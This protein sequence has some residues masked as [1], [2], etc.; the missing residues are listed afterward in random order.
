[1]DGYGTE[2]NDVKNRLFILVSAGMILPAAFLFC[3]AAGLPHV[4]IIT[5]TGFIISFVVKKPIR[6]SDR[7]IIYSIVI[8]LVLVVLLNMVFPIRADRFFHIGRLLMSHISAPFMLYLAVFATFYESSSYT[9]GFN[10]A[11]ALITLMFG[12]DFRVAGY[13]N[14]STMDFSDNLL[15]QGHFEIFF[16]ATATFVLLMILVAFN[17]ARKSTYHKSNWKIDWTKKAAYSLFLL[18]AALLSLGI[19][20]LFLTYKNEIRNL[21]NFMR[22]VTL[23]DLGNSSGIM[24]DNEID[25]NTTIKADRKKNSRVVMLRVVGTDIPPGYLRGKAYQFYSKGK[26]SIHPGNEMHCKFRQNIDKL[27]LNAFFIAQDPGD[28][29]EK[30]TIYPSSDCYADFL[31]IPGNTE[32]IEMVADRLTYSQNGTFSPKQWEKDGGYTA[33]VPEINQFASFELPAD[34]KKETYLEIPSELSPVLSKISSEIFNIGTT[35]NTDI[36]N[37]TDRKTAQKIVQF[38]TANF[39]YTLEP[40]APEKRVDPVIFFLTKTRKGH[41][42]LFASA[43]VMLLRKHGIPARYV[44][45]LLCQ[46]EH[47]SGKYFVSRLGDAHAWVE[48]YLR[49]EK[50]WI[51]VETTPASEDETDAQWGFFEGWMDRIKYAFKKILA[52]ARRGYIARAILLAF[53]ELAS[54]FW[55]IIKH[56]VGGVIFICS[57][58]FL[59]WKSTHK[60]ESKHLKLKLDPEIIILQKNIRKFIRKIEKQTSILRTS[61]T[62][63]DE[64]IEKLKDSQTVNPDQLAELTELISQY[65]QL[66]FSTK[67]VSTTANKHL[68]QQIQRVKI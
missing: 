16:L 2:T 40:E 6:Y 28:N 1:M 19:F 15:V 45:G 5:L 29:G 37:L 42:E 46:T 17:L 26:W 32:K 3:L 66:R 39:S 27:A 20:S 12:G 54:F 58:I 55:D 21:E 57:L 49:D 62:T 14:K 52:D 64:W 41:C 59:L 34:F 7:S 51:I 31:F 38:F 48:A 67:P 25:L 50:K 10:A 35:K 30:I 33:V 47:P 61:Q 44:T 53:T 56:P 23:P 22:R 11:F 43:T 24:F 68:K 9:L 4:F 18:A 63:P 60:K 36:I 65:N 8:S 13:I